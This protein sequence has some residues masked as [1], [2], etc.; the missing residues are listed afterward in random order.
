MERESFRSSFS[1]QSELLNTQLR[2]QDNGRAPVAK[3]FQV[4]VTASLHIQCV[5]PV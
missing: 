1:R 3:K 5:E 4:T 2:Q